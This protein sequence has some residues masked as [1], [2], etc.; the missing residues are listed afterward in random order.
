MVGKRK[1]FSP[2]TVLI[3]TSI[4]FIA[5]SISLSM[6]NS[7]EPKATSDKGSQSKSEL[8]ESPSNKEPENITYLV[9]NYNGKIAVFE[10]GQ[11]KPFKI[12]SVNID[13]LPDVD[14]KLLERGIET[15][16]QKKLLSILEDYCS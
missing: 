16:S 2:I 12:T 14:K 15:D 1:I 3:V 13:D 7:T 4:F 9:K 5:L 11:T 6:I 10:K 8:T